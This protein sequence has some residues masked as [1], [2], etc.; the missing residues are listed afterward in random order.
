VEIREPKNG[1]KPLK[2]FE[3]LLSKSNE[4][5]KRKSRNAKIAI[6]KPS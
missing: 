6:G 5:K 2:I 3:H 1:I 4:N